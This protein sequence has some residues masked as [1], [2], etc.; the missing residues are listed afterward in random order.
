[1]KKDFT[2]KKGCIGLAA[3]NFVIR[4]TPIKSESTS[5]LFNQSTKMRLLN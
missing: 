1:M 4:S 2:D 3:E 5:P